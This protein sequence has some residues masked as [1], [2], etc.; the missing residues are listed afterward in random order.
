MKRRF[1]KQ[2]VVI[3]FALFIA[4]YFFIQQYAQQ[5]LSDEPVVLTKADPPQIIMY[6][7]QYCQY[8]YLA[9]AFFKKHNLPY[10]E[11]DLDSSDKHMQTFYLLG[12]TGTPLLIVNKQIIHGFEE[13][14]RRKAL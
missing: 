3:I 4:G 1:Y 7:T 8:C 12:G 2:P 10:T 13:R 9:K 6:G 5:Q 11:Y 14:L